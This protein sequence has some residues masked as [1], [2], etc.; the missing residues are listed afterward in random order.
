MAS[1]WFRLTVSRRRTRL[2]HSAT[3]SRVEHRRRVRLRLT[4]KRCAPN[5]NVGCGLVVKASKVSWCHP[6]F[7]KGSEERWEAWR[8]RL[9]PHAIS[10]RARLLPSQLWVAQR[11]QIP[12]RH[13]QWVAPNSI[14]LRCEH[15]VSNLGDRLRA[16]VEQRET[17]R[18]SARRGKTRGNSLGGRW[19]APNAISWH[20]DGFVYRSAAG[21]PSNTLCGALTRRA[22]GD[23]TPAANG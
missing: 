17:L 3:H 23:G 13:A 11:T 5:D 9:K 6:S 19:V 10:G 7:A 14:S 12:N 15:C 20:R 22:R 18:R 4:V 2:T 8:G 21:V 16:Q 1:R